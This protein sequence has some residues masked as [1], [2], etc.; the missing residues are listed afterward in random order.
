MI[1]IKNV[2]ERSSRHKDF[3]NR[4]YGGVDLQKAIK[5]LKG[6]LLIMS[7]KGSLMLDASNPDSMDVDPKDFNTSLNGTLISMSIPLTV[8]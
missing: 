2:R 4:G 7:G 8:K 1:N 6:R 3:D 5:E